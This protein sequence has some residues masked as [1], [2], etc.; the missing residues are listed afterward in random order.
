L[1]HAVARLAEEHVTCCDKD[2]AFEYHG[3][4]P[5]NQLHVENESLGNK[6]LTHVG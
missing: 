5:L 4:T 2:Y 6:A 1:K 3:I